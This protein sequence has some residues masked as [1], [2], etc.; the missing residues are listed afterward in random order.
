MSNDYGK[1]QSRIIVTRTVDRHLSERG[2]NFEILERELGT[3][4]VF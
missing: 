3:S 1:H 4:T 2:D